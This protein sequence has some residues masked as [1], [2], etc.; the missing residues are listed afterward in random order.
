MN[1]RKSPCD[2]CGFSRSCPPELLGGSPVETYIGQAWGPFMVPCHKACDF[3][4]P[5]WKDKAFETLQCAGMAIFRA[6]LGSAKLM[7]AEIQQLP[8][9]TETVFKN[10][11]EFMAHHKQIAW[12]DAAIQLILKSPVSHMH[13]QLT[14]PD[15][16]VKR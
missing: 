9:D 2:E 7:P 4:D 11:I 12:E 13:D 6:N 8:A 15:T 5:E 10:E 1:V 3:S 16:K 14:H